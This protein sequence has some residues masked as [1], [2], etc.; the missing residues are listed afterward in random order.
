LHRRHVALAAAVAT[1]VVVPSALAIERAFEGSPPP[2]DV[3]NA[4]G[5]LNR[6]SDLA[7][8]YAAQQGFAVHAPHAIPSTTHGVAQVETGDGPVDL[9][10]ADS[11]TGGTCLLFDWEADG[12]SPSGVAYAAST[13]DEQA[14]ASKIAFGGEWSAEH[15]DYNVLYGHVYATDAATLEVSFADGTSTT[16][17]LVEGDY[18]GVVDHAQRVV[19]L[20]A[21]DATG[22]TVAQQDVAPP[23][24]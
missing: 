24:H 19:S 6:M 5:A 11:D 2:A 1:L 22:A 20:R 7:N 12:A 14:P 3:S 8:T 15:P 17:P 4:V 13:C 10:A 21:L 18:L 9:W 16:L 23:P